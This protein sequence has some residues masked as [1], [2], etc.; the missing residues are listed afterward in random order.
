MFLGP[1]LGNK[2]RAAWDVFGDDR[3]AAD[4]SRLPQ[5]PHGVVGGAG[6][7]NALKPKRAPRQAP[8]FPFSRE[9]AWFYSAALA[10]GGMDTAM[11]RPFR[12][13]DVPKIAAVIFTPMPAPCM[14][15]RETLWR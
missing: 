8:L 4:R 11:A 7:R 5:G 13:W 1:V 3:A 9:K 2:V 6:Q 10:P 14:F 15:S 12:F